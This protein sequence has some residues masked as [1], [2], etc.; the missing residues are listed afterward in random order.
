M[1][2]DRFLM[3]LGADAKE[4]ATRYDIQPFSAP[5]EVCG[6]TMT[7]SVPF[8]YS[9]LRGLRAP[10]CSCGSETM[11]YCVVRDYRAGDLFTGTVGTS[12]RRRTDGI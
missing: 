11:P 9:S 7:T 4:W 8:V 12:R 3:V 5:C 2:S 1:N 10:R 6:A